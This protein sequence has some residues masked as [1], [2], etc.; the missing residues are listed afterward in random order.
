MSEPI[1]IGSPAPDFTLQSSAGGSVTLS[2]L[3][4]STVVL[5][6]YPLDWSSVCSKQMD[7][8][9]ANISQFEAEG[10]KVFG[11]SVDSIH[12]HRAWAEARK[13]AFPLLADFHPKG[14]V[15]Q[16]YGV[17]NEERGSARRVTFLIDAEGIVRDVI[18][19]PA[20]EFTE[21]GM[22]CSAL[23]NVASA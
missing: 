8:Y 12:S 4:G 5:A 3:R 23:R 19:A 6:F 22:V 13:I 18:S 7:D 1:S 16:L 20:G 17:Y 9:S 10:A 11:I 14:A 15:A 2:D 21:S